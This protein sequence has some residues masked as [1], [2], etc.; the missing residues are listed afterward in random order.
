M[1][2]SSMKEEHIKI[3]LI[4]GITGEYSSIGIQVRDGLLLGVEEINSKGG[5]GGK[6][7]EIEIHDDKQN[8]SEI[9]KIAQKIKN[10]GSMIVLGP[11]T[12]SMAKE[13][14]ENQISKDFLLI[15]P[16][17]SSDYFNNK[18]DN[19]IRFGIPEDKNAIGKITSHIISENI[20]KVLMI[21]D[22]KNITYSMDWA[23]RFQSIFKDNGGESILFKVD[24][25]TNFKEDILK[26]LDSTIESV[27][28]SSDASTTAKIAQIIKNYRDDVKFYS[29]ASAY[30]DE[31]ISFGGKAVEGMVIVSNYYH[32]SQ[33]PK[34]LEFKEK[35]KKRFGVEPK[36]YALRSYET[37][38]FIAQA[39]KKDSDI[40]KLKKSILEIGKF[41]GLQKEYKLNRFGDIIDHDNMLLHIKDGRFEKL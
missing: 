16:T 29:S 15:S 40:S 41:D 13:L 35:Y 3:A 1:L 24:N 37:I 12:S 9:N 32:R 30:S 39:L 26:N 7:V 27:V 20:N 10:S 17:V 34:F 19:F 21:Y 5:I 38:N 11:V 33:E 18:D 14:L 6:K 23:L 36:A 28:I 22:S 25:S 8:S 2:F 4:A 31:L